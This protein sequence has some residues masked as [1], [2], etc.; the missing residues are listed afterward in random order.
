M[1]NHKYNQNLLI[2]AAMAVG[3]LGTLSTLFCST[4]NNKRG[5]E[6]AKELAKQ[7]IEKKEVFN[8]K[9]ILGGISG[10]IVGVTTALLLAP[11][12]GSDLIK[13]IYRPFAHSVKPAR[14]SSHKKA[15]SHEHAKGLVKKGA[16][17][18]AAEKGPQPSL[19]KS[20]SNSKSTSKSTSKKVSS[21]KEAIKKTPSK[22]SSARENKLVEGIE[23]VVSEFS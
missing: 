4:R 3:I 21:K 7:L 16:G 1:S 11:K 5:K 20:T 17:K 19:S 6:K 12:A 14:S 18:K 10:G 23:K 22:K 13:D 2:G 9:L 8:K 15:D